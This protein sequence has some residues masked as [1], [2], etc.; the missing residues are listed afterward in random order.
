MTTNQLHSATQAAAILE[1]SRHTIYRVANKH[2]IGRIITC[3]ES[4]RRIFTDKDIEAIESHLHY[5]VGRPPI[6][7]EPHE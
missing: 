1:C 6:N 4:T 5:A 3:G 2:R 7:K